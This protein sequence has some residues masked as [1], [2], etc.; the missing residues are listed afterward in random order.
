MRRCKTISELK[1]ERDN[2]RKTDDYHKIGRD[3]LINVL[4]CKK[5]QEEAN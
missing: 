5:G 1:Q 2:L 4:E 3:L